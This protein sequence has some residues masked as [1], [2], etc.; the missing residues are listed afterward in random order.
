MFGFLKRSAPTTS[1]VPSTAKVGTGVARRRKRP[2]VLG[3]GPDHPQTASGEEVS[4][5][6]DLECAAVRNAV[7]NLAGL[8]GTLPLAIYTPDDASGTEPVKDHPA[9]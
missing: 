6:R 2:L 7:D 5:Q 9:I 3:R 8:I 1:P 4:P